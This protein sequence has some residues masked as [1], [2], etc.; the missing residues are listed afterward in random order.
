[1]TSARR[2]DLAVRQRAV[3]APGAAV[4]LRQCRD[5]TV[6]GIVPA[7]VAADAPPE[8]RS[9]PVLGLPGGG[10]HGAPDRREA[11]EHVRAR[12]PVHGLVQERRGVEAKRRFPRLAER[13]PLLPG[14][15]VKLNGPPGGLGER[16]DSA[17]ARVPALPD[18]AAVV[19]RLPASLRK[20]HLGIRTEPD[21]GEPPVDP[22][23]LTPRLGDPAIHRPMGIKL[24]RDPILI[25]MLKLNGAFIIVTFGIMGGRCSC[26]FQ[27]L[28]SKTL[29]ASRHRAS[30]PFVNKAG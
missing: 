23:A 21:R 28:E 25:G 2:R 9:D 12:D 5:R 17:P 26:F 6:H 15:A 20:R 3:M 18:H 13:T 1:M 24:G 7:V 11:P 4:L 30:K 8:D 10:G 27:R 16:R 22:D 14:V 29:T 19:Q